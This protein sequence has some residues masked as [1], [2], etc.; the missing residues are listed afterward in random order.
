LFLRRASCTA[1]RQAAC[2]QPGAADQLQ[3]AS[4]NTQRC[5]LVALHSAL[6]A[7]PVCRG[8]CVPLH[9][10]QWAGSWCQPR[11][12][13]ATRVIRSMHRY[14]YCRGQ[15]GGER[16][17]RRAA[18]ATRGAARDEMRAWHPQVGFHSATD[19]TTTHKPHGCPRSEPEGQVCRNETLLTISPIHPCPVPI[20]R[21]EFRPR[22][23]SNSHGGWTNSYSTYLL[24]YRCASRRHVKPCA[25][26]CPRCTRPA[27]SA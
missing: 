5:G 15:G 18:A 13:G 12:Q 25:V 20:L 9:P 10:H 11:L 4:P 1:C 7:R 21:P 2:I 16:G 14:S 6:H 22:D 3:P 23:H 27:P 26:P 24:I 8:V 17:R 19:T